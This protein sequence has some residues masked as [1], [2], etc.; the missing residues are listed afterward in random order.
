MK[1]T[2]PTNIKRILIIRLSAIGDMLLAIPVLRALKEHYPSANL[3]VLVEPYVAPVIENNPYV[4]EIILFDKS[5]IYGLKANWQF[6]KSLRSKKFDLIVDL[7]CGTRT[8]LQTFFSGAKYRLGYKHKRGLINLAYNLTVTP[9]NVNRHTVIHQL[10]LVEDLGII[11]SNKDLYISI[12][13]NSREQKDILLKKL[14]IYNEPF[15][16]IHPGASSPY[17]IWYNSGWAR[18]ADIL[19]SEYHFNILFTGSKKEKSL[20]DDIQKLTLEKHFNLAG[21]TDLHTLSA[22]LECSKLYIG[23]DNG[24]MHLAAALQKPI[25][26]IFGASDPIRWAPWN[27]LY[28]IVSADVECSPCRYRTCNN[29]HKCMKLISPMQ[30]MENIDLCLAKSKE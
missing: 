10:Q 14:N 2:A 29:N 4:D 6:F 3:S 28:Y 30:V 22:L 11:P 18:I 9:E 19:K 27:T 20:I 13:E 8:A 7:Y 15:I 21:Q 16:I 5:K 25:I 24:I 17:K 1:L 12:S 26:A 23:S